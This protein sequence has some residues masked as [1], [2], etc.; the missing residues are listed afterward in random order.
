M[1]NDKDSA[2]INSQLDAVNWKLPG[3]EKFSE[4]DIAFFKREIAHKQ[5]AL[6]HTLPSL[7]WAYWPTTNRGFLDAPLLRRIADFIEIQNKPFWDEYEAL[8]LE[9]TGETPEAAILAA[10]QDQSNV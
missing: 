3:M 2:V 8:F 10:L 9:D 6:V 1:T 4:S 7:G 5:A